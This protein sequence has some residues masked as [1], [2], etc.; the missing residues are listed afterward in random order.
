MA[1]GALRIHETVETRLCSSFRRTGTISS[2][3]RALPARHPGVNRRINAQTRDNE[4]VN[5]AGH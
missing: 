2:Q 1:A 4:T 3:H 5:P